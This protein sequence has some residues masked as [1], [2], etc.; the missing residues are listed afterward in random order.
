MVKEMKWSNTFSIV[1]VITLYIKYILSVLQ[2]DRGM[3]IFCNRSGS[4]SDKEAFITTL[5]TTIH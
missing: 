3:S 5:D 4:F 2:I 1:N